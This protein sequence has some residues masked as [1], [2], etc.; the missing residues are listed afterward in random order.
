MLSRACESCWVSRDAFA[1]VA[2]LIQQR[3]EIDAQ[4]ASIIRRPMTS[5]HLGEWIASRIFDIEL[6][7]SATAPGIDGHFRSGSLAGKTVN[8]KWY[9]KHEG[10]LDISMAGDPDYYLV[11]AGPAAPATSSHGTHRPWTIHSVF[12][13][14]TTALMA[15]LHARG[16]AIGVA[17]SIHR[18]LWQD[19]E[20]YPDPTGSDLPLNDDQRSLLKLFL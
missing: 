17:T 3:N 12:L 6:E 14:E 5:G 2:Q 15:D 9:L 20:I 16:V 11:L 18:S 4:I 19:S 10:L 8:V 1:H 13:I 7:P